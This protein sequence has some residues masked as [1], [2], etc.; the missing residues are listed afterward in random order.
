MVIHINSL[1]F[2]GLKVLD[3]D[4]QVHLSECST[5]IFKVVGLP[6]KTIN[7]SKE[8]VISALSSLGLSLPSKRI[9]IN[10]SPADLVKEGSH[11]DLP[12]AVGI[13]TSLKILPQ[14]EISQYIILGELSLDGK[15]LGS[16]GIL[17]AAIGA[18]TRSK[19]LICS[20]TNSIEASW[21]GN[22]DILPVY[23]IMCLINHFKGLQV[24]SSPILENV[25]KM[26]VQSNHKVDFFDIKGQEEAK[27]AIE[28]AAAGGHHV[29]MCGPPGTGKSMLAQSISGILP[30]MT[31]E[32]ILECSMIS[33]VS[34]LIENGKLSNTR[35]FRSPH[36][37]CSSA[38]MVGGGWSNK[39]KPGEISLAHNGVLFLDELPE[40]S[41]SI[42]D[43]LRQPIETG[44]VLISRS[45]F[46]IVYP[47]NFQLIAAM[48]PCKCGYL[49]NPD[50][51]CN[52]APKCGQ[53]YTMKVS[54]PILDRFDI[55]I[56]VPSIE[57]W[58][59]IEDPKERSVDVAKRVKKARNL[60]TER[61]EGYGIRTNSQLSGQLLN[62]YILASDDS[63]NALNE[64]AKK[65]KISMRAYNK[66]LKISRTI[67]DLNNSKYVKIH[68]MLEAICYRKVDEFI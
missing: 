61:Y 62:E 54:G 26:I 33:S 49:Y 9:I 67:A 18:H 29:L 40:F 12:I 36:H 42:I 39:V 31:M 44:E 21:S 1:T 53:N 7:E 25:D 52:R 65:F 38:A 24:I 68:H 56:D 6:D 59:D 55:H 19:G 63:M 8:R 32:E 43:S 3:V 51:A 35:P 23:N 41:A 30:E 11:F 66:I 34:G 37:S 14:D 20:A 45:G 27:R 28:I 50:K 5:F 2:Q 17:P 13:L 48:N 10:L 57:V 22:T 64:A 58:E 16:P 15:V 60:Q 4:V 47:A 46:N